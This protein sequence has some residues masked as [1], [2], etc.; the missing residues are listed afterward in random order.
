MYVMLWT[1]HVVQTPAQKDEA[2]LQEE[3]ELQLAIALSQ[4]EA[5]AKAKEVS[6]RKWR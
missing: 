4:S 3:E 1:F 6:D 2:Q 5:E